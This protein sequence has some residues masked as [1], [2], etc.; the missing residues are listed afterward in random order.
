MSLPRA[1]SYISNSLLVLC[2]PNTH[3][4]SVFYAFTIYANGV[5]SQFS[6]K[7]RK[8]SFPTL[9]QHKTNAQKC[10]VQYMSR[11]QQLADVDYSGF[12]F[13]I[14]FALVRRIELA[15][16]L[17]LHSL[18]LSIAMVLAHKSQKAIPKCVRRSVLQKFKFGTNPFTRI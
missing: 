9:E 5:P 16:D 18:S 14:L 17:C 15:S 13:F 1:S 8:K 10:V 4:A 12:G 7:S 6:C 3:S 2:N 11:T